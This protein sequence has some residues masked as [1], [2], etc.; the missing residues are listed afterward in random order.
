MMVSELFKGHSFT[1]K[2]CFCKLVNGIAVLCCPKKTC[3]QEV[4]ISGV[5]KA[6]PQA[7]EGPPMADD[8]SWV[9]LLVPAF[10]IIFL[11]VPRKLL[12]ASIW[13]IQPQTISQYRV[14]VAVIG[15]VSQLNFVSNFAVNVYGNQLKAFFF[16]KL[17]FLF[18]LLGKTHEQA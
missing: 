10:L 1:Q 12:S 9:I 11:L 4:C 18:L 8:K 2:M 16:T 7:V 6:C 14:D 17:P 3:V 5:I 15:Y 13:K